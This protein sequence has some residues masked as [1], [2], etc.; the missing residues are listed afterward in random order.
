[1]HKRLHR[2][3]E[4]H[5]RGYRNIVDPEC[6]PSR[7]IVDI[8]M[9][10]QKT[11]PSTRMHPKRNLMTSFHLTFHAR[12]LH[13]DS[14]QLINGDLHFP[15]RW[16]FLGFLLYLKPCVGVGFLGRRV[17]EFMTSSRRLGFKISGRLKQRQCRV[18]ES[19]VSALRKML[20]ISTT[21]RRPMC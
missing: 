21:G 16:A 9:K 10:T 6:T 5:L 13:L 20:L 17:R 8:N 7:K 3:F 14:L 12:V 4:V 11:E 18:W 1:M 15:R 19:G 2:M